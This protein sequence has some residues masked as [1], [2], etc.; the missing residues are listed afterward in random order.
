MIPAA[1]SVHARRWLESLWDGSRENNDCQA[2]ILLKGHDDIKPQ[3]VVEA[4]SYRSLD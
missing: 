3:H 4:V 2:I 1:E